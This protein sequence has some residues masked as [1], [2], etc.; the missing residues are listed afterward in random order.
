MVKS[1]DDMISPLVICI[2]FST[3][4]NSNSYMHDFHGDIM[5]YN[6]IYQEQHHVGCIQNWVYTTL[7]CD[8]QTIGK[9]MINDGI[10]G[11]PIFSQTQYWW[12]NHAQMVH[13]LYLWW[14]H[15]S[16]NRNYEKPMEKCERSTRR[17]LSGPR[18]QELLQRQRG[19]HCPR[20]VP[21]DQW[22]S[23]PG[24]EPKRLAEIPRNQRWQWKIPHL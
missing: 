19:S 3:T 13:F 5:W 8:H 20:A 18:S 6:R 12:V 2:I 23:L 17:S 24:R 16:W 14:F 10:W 11:Y 9:M 22:R 21:L 7:S 4:A 15:G 1:W